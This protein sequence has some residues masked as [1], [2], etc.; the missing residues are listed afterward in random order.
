LL[1]L[2]FASSAG[3][4]LRELKYEPELVIDLKADGVIMAGPLTVN[5][6]GR[7]V[8]QTE[9]YTGKLIAIDS[10]GNKQPWDIAIGGNRRQREEADIGYRG[11]SGWVGDSL[12]IGD[13]MFGQ[14]VLIDGNGK[15]VKSIERPSWIRPFWRDRHKYPVFRRMGWEALYPDG[16]M[17]VEPSNPRALFD[18]PGFDRSKTYLM[19]VNADGKILRVI[20]Q[21]PAFDTRLRLV[22]GTRRKAF[23]HPF[24]TRNVW[25]VSADGERIAIAEPL[26]TANDSG[27][28]LVTMLN[29]DGDTVFT[30]RYVVETTRNSPEAI[31]TALAGIESFGRHSAEWIRDT[32]RKDIPVFASRV[33]GIDVGIDHSVWV[34]LRSP[35]PETRLF[36]IDARGNP[37]GTVAFPPSW[38]P[39][40][41]SLDRIWT[42]ERIGP[43]RNFKS[44]S[45]IRLK[46]ATTTAARPAR[47]ASTSASPARSKQPE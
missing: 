21:V 40:G 34:R 17:L 32:V 47:N 43:S 12:W 15:I 37:V 31:A 4:Q 25:K 16:T 9:P 41:Y 18:T 35:V 33:I 45:V 39:G 38:R 28:F 10:L 6:R 36:V 44:S 26:K 24:L 8:I 46:R 7:M 2:L 27:A 5:H 42:T 29:A 13:D 11:K 30:R 23:G 14:V 19:R 22:D 1:L 20:T 3:A